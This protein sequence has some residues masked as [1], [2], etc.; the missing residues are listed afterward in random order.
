[1]NIKKK[2][3]YVLQKPI[4]KKG[5]IGDIISVTKGF[6]RYLERFAIAKRATNEIIENL[7]EN[8]KLWLEKESDNEKQA[9]LMLEKIKDIT[10]TL[11]RRVSQGDGLYESVRA[12]HIVADFKERGIDLKNNNIQINSQIKNL[13]MHKFI[14]HIYGSCEVELNLEVISDSQD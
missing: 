12:E 5:A 10:I 14:V 7:E 13:G 9:N 11:K 1:M 2:I 4:R 6:G 3:S 8:R